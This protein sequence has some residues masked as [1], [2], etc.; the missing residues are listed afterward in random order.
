MLRALVIVLILCGSFGIAAILTMSSD[1]PPRKPQVNTDIL[2]ETIPVEQVDTSFTV[3]S[4]G[5]VQPEIETQLSAEISGT[6]TSISPNFTA[7]GVFKAGETLLRIDPANYEVAVT[8]AEAL[9]ELRRI[10]YEGAKKLRSQGYRAEAELASAKAA[11]ATAEA[12]L[13]RARRNLERTRIQLPYDGIVRS[14]SAD[15]GQFVSPGT[16][17]GV[18][19]STEAALVR[20]PLTESDLAFVDLPRVG[21]EPEAGPAVTLTA[22]VSGRRVDFLASI[23][24]TEGVVDPS[25]R[26]TFAVA[27]IDDPYGLESGATALPIGTFVTATVEGNS[28]S[29]VMRVPSYALHGSDQLMFRDEESRLRIRAVDVIRADEDWVYFS[30]GAETGDE[31]ITTALESPVNGMPVRVPGDGTTQTADVRSP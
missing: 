31:V 19:F 16:R 21:E 18:T 26:V 14:K 27:R 22:N 24:R 2:V 9:L 6:I 28:L 10:E 5:S 7:G 1:T 8:Q 13:V 29:H 20:L 12:E 3:Q 4:Q 15:L 17:L 30:S 23:V 25:S 11:L